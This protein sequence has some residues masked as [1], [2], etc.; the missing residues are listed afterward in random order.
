[1]IPIKILQAKAINCLGIWGSIE[2]LEIADSAQQYGA[3]VINRPNH[4]AEDF[5]G[6]ADVL[7]HVIESLELTPAELSVM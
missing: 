4:L 5:A 7:I 2:D 6:Y 3:G 1:M